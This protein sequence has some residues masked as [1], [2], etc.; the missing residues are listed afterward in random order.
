MP[1]FLPQERR[2]ESHCL[3]PSE[4]GQKHWD[5]HMW[6]SCLSPS[7]V[8]HVRALGPTW[9]DGRSVCLLSRFCLWA[10]LSGLVTDLRSHLE[11]VKETGGGCETGEWEQRL[12]T[13]WVPLAVCVCVCPYKVFIALSAVSVI[14]EA[15]G[16]SEQW[17]EFRRRRC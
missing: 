16:I 2:K 10:G 7:I 15:K 5:G 6:A 8:Q 11:L 13:Y 3:L 1:S 17:R 14:F 12:L 9:S 4:V